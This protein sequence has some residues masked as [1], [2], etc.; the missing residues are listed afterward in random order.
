MGNYAQ[1]DKMASG[2][3]DSA[4]KYHSNFLFKVPSRANAIDNFKALTGGMQKAM[5]FLLS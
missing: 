5:P 1:I 3:K 2:Q 4:P